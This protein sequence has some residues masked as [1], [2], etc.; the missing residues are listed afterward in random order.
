MP[1]PEPVTTPDSPYVIDGLQFAA[2]SDKVFRQMREGNVDAVHATIAYHGSFRDAVNSVDRW[3]RRF[4][5]HADLIMPG[6]KYEDLSRARASGRTAIFLGLQNPSPIED[7]IGLVEILHR[8]GVRFMQLTYNNQSLLG[9][10]HAEA[11][12][13]GVTRMGREAIAEMNRV[14]MVV[15]LSHA[16]ARTAAEAIACSSRPVAVTHA[17]PR[18]WHSVDR[19][20][21]DHVLQALAAAGGMLGFSLYPPHLKGGSDCPLAAFCQMAADAAERYGVGILGMGSDLVQGRPASALEWMRSGRWSRNSA[22]GQEGFPDPVSW[23]RD[24]RDFETISEG[25]S[26]AGFSES[27]SAAILGVNWRRFYATAFAPR[28]ALAK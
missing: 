26:K 25:L 16:G 9:S 5:D 22:D 28:H 4:R 11:E 24:N 15:D 19:N 8:L 18:W 2:W 10:G 7:D 20:V 23:F 1:A 3:N 27:D 6:A 12:D 14:G 13:S 17:N 21:P